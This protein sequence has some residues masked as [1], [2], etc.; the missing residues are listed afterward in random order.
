VFEQAFRNIDDILHIEAGCTT[1]LDYTKYGDS[2]ADA[3]IDLGRPE[4]ISR[5]FGGFQKYLY[6][7]VAA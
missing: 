3:G 2:I 4:E 7:R 6:Q 1:V 5:V